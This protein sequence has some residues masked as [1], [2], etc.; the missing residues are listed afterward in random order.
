MGINPFSF[1][2][3]LLFIQFAFL[4]DSN[5]IIVVGNVTS[6]AF[7]H[8]L[9]FIWPSP[10]I[11]SNLII[12]QDRIS[13]GDFSSQPWCWFSSFSVHSALMMLSFKITWVFKLHKIVIWP[14]QLLQHL[15]VF[16]LWQ[17][18]LLRWQL[19][20]LSLGVIIPGFQVLGLHTV[21]YMVY[22]RIDMGQYGFRIPRP[23]TV[24][25]NF[26]GLTVTGQP[27]WQWQP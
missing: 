8:E 22:G 2:T 21:P 16:N 5:P 12:F 20:S 4:L 24:P 1:L 6:S 7:Y 19:A 3:H 9:L 13:I 11:G 14:I 10:Y 15:H 26:W 25:S 27:Y 23:V 18:Y 17:W